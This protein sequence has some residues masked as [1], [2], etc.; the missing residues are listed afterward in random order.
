MVLD[1]KAIAK[2]CRGSKITTARHLCRTQI[3][4]FQAALRNDGPLTIGCTQE[5]ALFDELAGEAGRKTPITYANVRETGGWSREGRRA[6]PK[7]AALLA[8]AAETL[9]SVVTVTL[10]SEGVILVYGCD[11]RAVEAGELLKDDLDVTVLL[12]PPAA[13]APPR[14]TE[15]PI[16]RGTI[17]NAKGHVGEFEI[18]VDDFARPS[19]SSRGANLRAVPQW[20]EIPVRHHPRHLRWDRPVPCADLRDGYLRADPERPG[21]HSQ[22]RAAGA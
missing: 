14:N 1:E 8:A 18:T 3:D 22:G 21:R 10:E 2:G 11:E 12:K 5:A 19:P 20:R 15:F 17:R 9:P 7:M 4:R 6:G 16:V 13:I